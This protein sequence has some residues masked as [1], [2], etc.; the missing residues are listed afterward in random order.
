MRCPPTPSGERLWQR[1]K[2][3]QLGVGFRSQHVLG[4]YIV[5][6]AAARGRGDKH[7]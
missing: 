2:G 4:S 3:S 5:D 6:F 1:L 7:P